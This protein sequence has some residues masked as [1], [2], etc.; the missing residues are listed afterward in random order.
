MKCQVQNYM[1]EEFA[2]DQ[3][4]ENSA[5]ICD[6]YFKGR[7]NAVGKMLQLSR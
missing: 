2:F 7:K 6:K 1:L 4:A 5:S 3:T